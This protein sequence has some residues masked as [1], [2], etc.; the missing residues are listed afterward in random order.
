MRTAPALNS[1]NRPLIYHLA[2]YQKPHAEAECKAYC[3]Y[4]KG[5]F[6]L[7]MLK[8]PPRLAHIAGVT[9]ALRPHDSLPH[10][11]ASSRA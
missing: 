9:N 11:Y 6:T 5:W 7:K 3:E 8:L 2:M 4:M 10:E 1:I